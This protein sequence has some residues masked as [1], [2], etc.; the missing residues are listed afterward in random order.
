MLT[1]LCLQDIHSYNK[2]QAGGHAANNLITTIEK[3]RR[4][5]LQEAFDV[6]E[7]F[8]DNDV[9]EFLRCKELL[10][11]WVPTTAPPSTRDLVFEAVKVS[12]AVGDHPILAHTGWTISTFEYHLSVTTLEILDDTTACTRHKDV[13]D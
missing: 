8:F 7:R 9:D 3:E 10:P 11:S 2:E 1:S 13:R 4:T 5:G 6:V 12:S